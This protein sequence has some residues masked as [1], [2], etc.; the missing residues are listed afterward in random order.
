MTR[1]FI[2]VRSILL[3]TC[4]RQD[5][6]VSIE[7]C[8]RTQ[9][10]SVVGGSHKYCRRESSRNGFKSCS[11]TSPLYSRRGEDFYFLFLESDSQIPAI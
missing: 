6:L 4:L 1:F 8:Q 5:H 7:S 9:L 10:Y 3:Y 11:A 2:L